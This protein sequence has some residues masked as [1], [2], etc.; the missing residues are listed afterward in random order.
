MLFCE[1]L[2]ELCS[3]KCPRQEGNWTKKALI[4]YV[5]Y[6]ETAPNKHP[7][8]HL[9][10]TSLHFRK[11]NK[12]TTLPFC[13]TCPDAVGLL[14]VKSTSSLSNKDEGPQWLSLPLYR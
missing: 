14:H 10:I 1:S 12:N 7:R 9:C 3:K 6:G 5:Y 13:K 4:L 2:M 8:E 11:D